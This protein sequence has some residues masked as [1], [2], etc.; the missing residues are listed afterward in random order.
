MPKVIRTGIATVKGI[1]AP[2]Y[3]TPKPVGQVPIGPT[4]TLTDV[5]ELAARLGSIVTFDRR[6]NVVW[7]DDFEDN[8]DK[9]Q[10]L[11]V[12][13]IGGEA[14]LSNARAR[15]GALSARLT[16][17]N[18]IDASVELQT[19]FYYPVF[20]NLGFEISFIYNGNMSE[21][22]WLFQVN[23]GTHY[24]LAEVRLNPATNALEINDHILGWVALAPTPTLRPHFY[25]FNTL[26]IVQNPKTRKYIRLILNEVE[27]ILD[28]YDLVYALF[29]QPANL[30]ASVLVTTGVAANEVAYFA[31]AIITQN[32]P[33][34]LP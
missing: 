11:V 2:D 9:W 18:V 7:L 34:N 23:D 1:G 22:R 25:A 14:V 31:D 20:S 17:G 27:Y 19:V 13:G 15:K 32:E 3:A 10:I 26:K 16:T 21:Y 24:T 8:I 4:Y 30:M 5:A 33:E 12:G 28:G 6:G 29:P